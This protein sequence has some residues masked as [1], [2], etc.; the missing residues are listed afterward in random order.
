VTTAIRILI[1]NSPRS[2]RQ[3]HAE[4]LRAMRPDADVLLAEPEEL[5][6]EIARFAPHLVLCSELTERLRA[7]PI[8]W[9]LLY[10]G[11]ADLAV[12]S[13]DRSQRTIQG[14]QLDDVLRVVDETARR[15]AASAQNADAPVPPRD[16][17]PRP[18]AIQ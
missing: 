14:V 11:G 16:A 12:A 10:P 8:S 9:I 18:E 13:I 15:A 4:A 3:A 7:A 6:G 1:A 17:E 2:Y 5:D